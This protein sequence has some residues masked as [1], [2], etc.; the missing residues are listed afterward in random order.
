MH[1]TTPRR[2]N[3]LYRL[4]RLRGLRQKHLAVLLGY[5]GTSMISR[6]ENGEAFP[7]LPAGLLLELALGTKLSE[8]YVD[9]YEELQRRIIKRAAR[10][11]LSVRR[12]IRGRVLG[13]D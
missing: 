13:K 9:L 7:S 10:L 1:H 6:F 12:P 3:Y 2:K 11:P 4:R 5:K 8:M